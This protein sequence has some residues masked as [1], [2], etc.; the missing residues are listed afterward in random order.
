[1]M[2]FTKLRA[3]NSQTVSPRNNAFVA[4]L[5]TRIQQIV[6]SADV[7]ISNFKNL[8]LFR[9]NELTSFSD[10]VLENFRHPV[11]L[12][13]QFDIRPAIKASSQEI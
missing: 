8:L 6:P 5:G 13:R 3:R 7:L 11:G 2:V 4:H 9:F 1:M 10:H 12:L